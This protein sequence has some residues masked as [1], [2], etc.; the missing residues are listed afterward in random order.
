MFRVALAVFG[1]SPLLV[2][3]L[4]ERWVPGVVRGFYAFQCHGLRDRVLRVFGHPMPVCSRCFGIYLGLA[5]A[6]LVASF[7]PSASV[8]RGWLVAAAALM[9]FDALVLEDRTPWLRLLTGFLLAF[10]AAKLILGDVR[11]PTGA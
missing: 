10:P 8:L 7:R 6:A 1:V 5:V 9:A 4:P 3:A 11:A 2:T